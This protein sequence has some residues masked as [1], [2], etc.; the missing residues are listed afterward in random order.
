MPKFDA[1]S[2]T[3]H[4]AECS[5]TSYRAHASGAAMLKFTTPCAGHDLTKLA[6]QKM[7]KSLAPKEASIQLS[8]SKSLSHVK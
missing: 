6:F 8:Q 5:F 1:V 3:H 7:L 4:A 2:N